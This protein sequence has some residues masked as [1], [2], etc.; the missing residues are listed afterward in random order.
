M[1]DP[2]SDKVI[3]GNPVDLRFLSLAERFVTMST[4][5]GDANLNCTLVSIILPKATCPGPRAS[6]Q[7]KILEITASCEF[8]LTFYSEGSDIANPEPNTEVNCMSQNTLL[9]FIANLRHT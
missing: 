1:E 3:D 2:D 8:F 9:V 7:R 4:I 5:T 6:E